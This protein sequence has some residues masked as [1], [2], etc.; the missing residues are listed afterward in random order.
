MYVCV[1]CGLDPDHAG[2][3]LLT[4]DDPEDITD[5]AHEMAPEVTATLGEAYS[6]DDIQAILEDALIL[7]DMWLVEYT[8]RIQEGASS[9]DNFYATGVFA[10]DPDI[11][12]LSDWEI[13]ELSK[14][15]LD[16]RNAALTKRTAAIKKLTDPIVKAINDKALNLVYTQQNLLEAQKTLVI[17]K[18]TGKGTNLAITAGAAANQV[19]RLKAVDDY[20][21]RTS[22]GKEGPNTLQAAKNVDKAIKASFPG[23]TTS[24]TVLKNWQSALAA[25]G[26][27]YS[28]FNVEILRSRRFTQEDE[29]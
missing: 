2:P 14:V 12:D 5:V 24:E 3:N 20:L 15:D 19:S 11:P 4:Y 7:P 29:I 18:V 28:E 26:N 13:A 10:T 1:L 16:K 25:A 9:K 23:V 27:T 8:G 21:T 17:E 6:T 22:A